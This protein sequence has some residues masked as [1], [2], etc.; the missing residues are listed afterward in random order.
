MFMMIPLVQRFSTKSMLHFVHSFTEKAVSND[1]CVSPSCTIKL[2]CIIPRRSQPITIHYVIPAAA[3][4][5]KVRK[6][7]P[8]LTTYI[9]V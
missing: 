7:L 9:Y 8:G 6:S 4:T 1:L 5:G 3:V 2:M